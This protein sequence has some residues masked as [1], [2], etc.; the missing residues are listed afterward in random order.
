MPR[1]SIPRNALNR[2]TAVHLGGARV[3]FVW[4]CGCKR[5]ETVK[6]P[7]GPLGESAVAQLVRN[8]RANGVALEQCKRHPEWYERKSPLPR[9]NEQNPPSE[10][11]AR[12]TQRMRG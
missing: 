9:L 7:A 1:R 6:G 8:W 3:R 12:S 5:V 10:G 2:G 4:A 11:L